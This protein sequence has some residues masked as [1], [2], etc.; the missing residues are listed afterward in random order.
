MIHY[1]GGPITPAEVAEEFYS[2]RHAMVSFAEPRDIERAARNAQSFALDNG[3]FSLWRS[4]QPTDWPKY[5]TWVNQWRYHPGFDFAIIPDVIDGDETANDALIDEWPFGHAGVPVWHLHESLER[6]YVMRHRWPRIALGTSGKWAT[7]GTDAWWHR[8]GEVMETIGSGTGPVKLHG[9]RMLS[10]EIFP[11]LPLSS[12]DSTNIARN[13]ALK[14]MGISGAKW[15]ADRIESFN[16]AEKWS[17]LPSN[18]E[19]EWK[20]ESCVLTN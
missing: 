11:K 3:A 13:Y 15:M 7:P 10:V 19:F 18:R 2:G 17:G 6:L 1:H 9:L 14:K 8:M 16:S 4:G 5:Y 12:A 20:V